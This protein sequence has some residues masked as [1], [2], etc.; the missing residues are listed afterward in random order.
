MFRNKNEISDVIKKI[1]YSA[2]KEN[3]IVV[4]PLVL[5]LVIIYVFKKTHLGKK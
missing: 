5:S 3:L 2:I 1:I 4:S